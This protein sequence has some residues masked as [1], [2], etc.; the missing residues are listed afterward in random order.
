MI[1][2]DTGRLHWSAP[3]CFLRM[4]GTVILF[5]SAPFSPATA[6]FLLLA[7]LIAESSTLLELRSP[8]KGPAA[9]AR[10]L[11]GPLRHLALARLGLGL[12][13]ALALALAP[14][15]AALGLL[16]LGELAERALFFRAV[17]PSR[18]P[19]MPAGP[20]HAH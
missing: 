17:D 10:L 20:E 3:R 5:A 15:P 7:K 12:A 14:L 6:S 11:V 19:G 13:A 18:M 9:S 1:Y 8:S 16:L 4:G 2:V